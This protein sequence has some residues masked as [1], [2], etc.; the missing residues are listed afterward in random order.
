MSAPPSTFAEEWDGDVYFDSVDR[1]HP[2]AATGGALYGNYITTLMEHNS[3]KYFAKA[4][5]NAEVSPL[6]DFKDFVYY[7]EAFNQKLNKDNG[8]YEFTFNGTEMILDYQLIHNVDGNKG[9]ILEL[10]IDGELKETVNTYLENTNTLYDGFVRQA[11]VSGLSEG[12]HTARFVRR[13][14]GD[15]AEIISIIGAYL[16]KTNGI[17]FTALT[18]DANAFTAGTP[19]T[20]HT[21]YTSGEDGRKVMLAVAQYDKDGKL[22]DVSTLNNRMA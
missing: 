10:Y 19:V 3:N 20:V 7:Y 9:G 11:A 17:A 22:T 18:F 14:N 21:L 5:S 4:K 12:A 1:T 13:D 15:D 2:F 6:T 16:K 8:A